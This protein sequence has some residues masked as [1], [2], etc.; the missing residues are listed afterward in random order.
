MGLFGIFHRSGAEKADVAAT[1]TALGEARGTGDSDAVTAMIQRILS[2]GLDGRGFYA[3]AAR[4][5]QNALKANGGDPERAIDAL[6]RG[7]IR[8]AAGGG[9]VTSL[10]GFVTMPVAIPANLFEFYVTATRTAGAIASI[11][12]YD[13][14]DP[15]IRTAVLL[16]LVGSK[17]NDILN[18]AG[19]TLGSNTISG[20]AE[21]RLPP[22]AVM[23]INK[24]VG[25]RLL[26]IIGEKTLSRFGRAVPVLGGAVG[27]FAD[28]AMM[29]KI[30][31]QART[32]FPRTQDAHR[33]WGVR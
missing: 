1:T 22:A 8:T 21:R 9:F 23:M 13:V 28:G 30:A 7:S 32:E 12:G 27:A 19:V 33:D 24:A 10:G 15:T 31:K 11:R 4:V 2:L 18:K 29:S 25:F 16:T 3:G 6:A 26:K 20:L 5:A 14:K 17:A